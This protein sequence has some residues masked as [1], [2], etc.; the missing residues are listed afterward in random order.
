MVLT[1]DCRDTP[2]KAERF[3]KVYGANKP[4]AKGSV[5]ISM[6]PDD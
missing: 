1:N 6:K 5:N 4:L 2:V 3:G